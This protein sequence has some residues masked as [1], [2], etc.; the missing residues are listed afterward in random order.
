MTTLRIPSP[1]KPGS[2]RGEGYADNRFMG[3][4]ARWTDS[5]GSSSLTRGEL[6]LMMTARRDVE[7]SDLAMETGPLRETFQSSKSTRPDHNMRQSR[8][9]MH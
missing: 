3:T 9:Y 1:T 7:V 5:K 8:H 6:G 4:P 2:S